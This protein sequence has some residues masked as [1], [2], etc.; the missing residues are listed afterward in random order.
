[1]K[2]R[3]LIGT[4]LCLAFITLFLVFIKPLLWLPK[5]EISEDS[6]D[7]GAVKPMSVLKHTFIIKNTGSAQL[8]LDVHPNCRRCIRPELEKNRIPPNGS[9]KLQ[10]ELFAKGEG[11]YESTA[12]IESNDPGQKIKKVTLK[13]TIIKQ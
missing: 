12:I 8:T 11:T 5:L 9:T 4:L 2:K 6:W 1:V 10:V 3:L 13:A 7:F